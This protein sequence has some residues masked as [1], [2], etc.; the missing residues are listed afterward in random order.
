[1]DRIGNKV[2]DIARMGADPIG[3]C[4]KATGAALERAVRW[5]T[6]AVPGPPRCTRF[7]RPRMGAKA[8]MAEATAF[9]KK[10]KSVCDTDWQS[11]KMTGRR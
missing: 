11:L 3:S 4:A 9:R 1:M 7:L 6:C 10:G 8:V 2:R 5:K